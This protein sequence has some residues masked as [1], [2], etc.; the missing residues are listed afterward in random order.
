MKILKYILLAVLILAAIVLVVALI[1]PKKFHAE[2]SVTIN[3]PV[4]EVYDYV[5]YIRNQENYGV[6]FQMDDRVEK[7]FTGEDGLVGFTYEWKSKKVGNGKQVITKLENDKK[8]EMDIFFNGFSD[9]AKSYITTEAIDSTQTKV[10]WG[11]DGE[12][13]IPLNLMSLFYDMNKDFIQGTH[14]LKQVLEKE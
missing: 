2:G 14:N 11:I 13:P 5:K 3:K 8:V 10:V 12:M 9:A 7:T 6:W 1:A 4:Q